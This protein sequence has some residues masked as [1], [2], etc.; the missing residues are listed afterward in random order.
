MDRSVSEFDVWVQ[1]KIDRLAEL[2]ESVK[3][4]GAV[5]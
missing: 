4:R 3:E 1:V 5:P 2:A